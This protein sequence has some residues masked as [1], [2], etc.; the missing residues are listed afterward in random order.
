VQ[1]S[2]ISNNTAGG[3]GGGIAGAGS[4]V[5]VLKSNVLSNHAQGG[6]G[7]SMGPAPTGFGLLTIDSTT[8][9]HNQAQVTGGGV[10]ADTGCAN[11]FLSL[12]IQT[13]TFTNNSTVQSVAGGGGL[14]QNAICGARITTTATDTLFSGNLA[15]GAAGG[16]ISNTSD[17]VFST[18]SSI[19]LQQGSQPKQMMAVQNNQAAVGAGVYQSGA[20]SGLTLRFGAKVTHN[21]ASVNGGGVFLVCGALYTALPGAQNVFNTPNNLVTGNCV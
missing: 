10:L 6:A 17:D 19:T 20:S 3:D 4:I 18:N 1:S 8:V 12:V 5:H 7:I 15:P 9:D 11:G 13:A 14:A 21:H 2:T 16:A